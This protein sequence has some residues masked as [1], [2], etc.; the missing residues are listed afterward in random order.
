[1]TIDAEPFQGKT[2]AITGT[3]PD[4]T[5]AQAAAALKE[6]GAKVSKSVSSRT[7]VLVSVGYNPSQR[8]YFSSKE[9]KARQNNVTI[10]NEAQFAALLKGEPAHVVLALESK[11]DDRIEVST[12][13]ALASFR[14]IVYDAPTLDTW[15][16]I[17]RLV[18]QCPPEDLPLVIDY[19][20][21]HLEAWPL[22]YEQPLD[23][24]PQTP[25]LKPRTRFATR[26]LRQLPSE[27]L[28]DLF[29]GIDSP[30]LRLVR[31]A[32]FMGAKMTGKIGLKVL[33]CASLNNLVHINLGRNKLSGQFFKALRAATHLQSLKHLSL[34]HSNLGESAIKGLCGDATWRATHLDLRGAELKGQGLPLLLKS[35]CWA[36]LEIL[37]L[38]ALRG[39][40]HDPTRAL[41]DAPHIGRLRH[42]TLDHCRPISVA[43]FRA[44]MTQSH[45]LTHLRELN[46]VSDDITHEHIDAL[47]E[48]H[49]IHQLETL[50][51]SRK[52]S[53]PSVA[54][55][56]GAPHTQHLKK[57]TLNGQ[58]GVIEALASSQIKPRD[59]TIS[60]GFHRA[61][62]HALLSSDLLTDVRALRL[63]LDI[64][65]RSDARD[66]VI[67]LI[68][69][70]Q[71][72]HLEA[73]T[74]MGVDVDDDILHT[75]I[76]AKDKLN[77][78]HR[79]NIACRSHLNHA[80]K[81]MARRLIAAASYNPPLQSRFK[82]QF[83]HVLRREDP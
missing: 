46:L 77:T 24:R 8:K 13:D 44:L 63:E 6:R 79:F 18:D 23:R 56:I 61:A 27:W 29:L 41:A 19:V 33:E 54:A 45:Q 66:F 39:R 60:H 64:D 40:S 78:M 74:L 10:I 57:L 73:L 72:T 36:S 16:A 59:L 75:L 25:H 58:H 42:L 1:M 48:A 9:L 20:E 81:A 68:Q 67:Q 83:Y 50:S 28:T 5:R 17:W 4:M 11:P 71:L 53:G 14:E 37:N 2:W 26:R 43:N 47:V 35:P 32:N 80:S 21:G 55:L 62:R 82:N 76:D 12:H 65:E 38:G 22:T 31:S 70:P 7:D 34:N 52:C 3:L 15:E 30:K 69:H 51:L 49:H